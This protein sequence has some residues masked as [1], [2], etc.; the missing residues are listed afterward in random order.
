L[1]LEDLTT[2]GYRPLN[3]KLHEVGQENCFQILR[4]LAHFHAL[5]LALNVQYGSCEKVRK[6]FPH[7][8]SSYPFDSDAFTL[9]LL[10]GVIG[11]VT[12]LRQLPDQAQLADK[13][14]EF[15]ER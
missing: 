5:C 11:A 7:V 9:A 1:V 15:V 4:Q 3:P 13:L 6:R 2:S 14:D 8:C 12:L 10:Q